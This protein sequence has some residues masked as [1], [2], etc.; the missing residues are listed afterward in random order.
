MGKFSFKIES[1]PDYRRL[2]KDIKKHS[3]LSPFLKSW[4]ARELFFECPN[5]A[6]ATVA[7]ALLASV[8]QKNNIKYT[9]NNGQ[10]QEV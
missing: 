2:I 3:K 1:R 10:E 7:S 8:L 6:S 5:K 9:L 4:A